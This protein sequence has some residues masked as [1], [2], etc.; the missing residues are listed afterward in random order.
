MDEM[1]SKLSADIVSAKDTDSSGTL[2]ASELGISDSQLAEFDTDGDGKLS[3]AELSAALAS[4]REKMQAQMSTEMEQN[5][6]LGM[7]QSS[8][9]SSTSESE[10]KPSLDDMI[11]GIFGGTSTSDA[12]ATESSSESTSASA[13]SASS[14]LASNAGDTLES[15]LKEMDERL[16][17]SILNEKD[18]NG[19]GVLSAEELGVSST[20]L[21]ELDSDGD[22]TISQSE[23]TE[24]LKSQ[25]EEMMAENG[26]AMPPPPPPTDGESESS[27]STSTSSTSSLDVDAMMT[28]MFSSSTTTATGE[29]DGTSDSVTASAL[30]EFLLR[31]K[32]SNAYQSVDSFMSQL[33][34]DGSGISQSVSMS[35]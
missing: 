6:Q 4:Q 34:G 1:D 14:T 26:G 10:E 9:S 19:D 8:M 25:R 2:S 30:S 5:G 29:A 31:Q 20:Q 24:G 3:S 23:L 18:T 35:A 28:G 17:N 12:S 32:A 16:A 11:S 22:G 7:L 33:F 21:S 27:S 13:V 15:F